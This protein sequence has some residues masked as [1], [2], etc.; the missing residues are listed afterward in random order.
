ML[1]VIMLIVIYADCHNAHYKM[2][3]VIMLSH[4]GS[5]IVLGV[6]SPGTVFTTFHFH[7]ILQTVPIS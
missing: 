2:L 6:Y 4:Y 7:R 5:I 1:I 3:I